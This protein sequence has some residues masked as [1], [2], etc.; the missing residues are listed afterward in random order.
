MIALHRLIIG[1]C[2]GVFSGWLFADYF[3]LWKDKIKSHYVWN[4]MDLYWSIVCLL[5]ILLGHFITIWG[6]YFR[7]S[8]QFQN[9]ISK[10]T[11]PANKK[12]RV[13]FWERHDSRFGCSIKFWCLAGLIVT[14]NLYWFVLTTALSRDAYVKSYGLSQ[15]IVRATA[16]GS[17][18]AVL[19]DTSIILFLVLRR[20]M[21]HAIGFTYSE[22]IPLHRWLGVTMLVWATIHAAFYSAY[23][24]MSGSFG[25]DI[26][27]TDKGRGT[28]DMPGVFAWFG[29]LI[30]A[31]FALPQ[32]RRMV[33]PVFLYVHRAGTFVFFIGLIMHYPSV[34]L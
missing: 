17:S 28:R 11:T 19:L 16:Y 8:S 33:Y 3:E 14:M 18:Q 23:L 32:F 26:A 6:N 20:S 34:M 1:L 21:L 27:F 31:F 5:P 9:S 30:M 15:G 12:Q 10:V 22:I 7:A 29:M 4:E 24:I 13:S 2:L 25:T